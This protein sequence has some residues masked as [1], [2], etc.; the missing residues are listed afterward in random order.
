MKVRFLVTAAACLLLSSCADTAPTPSPN[1]GT[2]T[3]VQTVTTTNGTNADNTITEDT[4]YEK[5]IQSAGDFAKVITM[6]GKIS[7]DVIKQAF[8]RLYHEYPEYFWV[9]NYQYTMSDTDLT[10]TIDSFQDYSVSQVQQ[11]YQA[12]KQKAAGIVAG[13]P[14]NIPDYDKILQI[15]DYLVRTTQYDYDGLEQGNTQYRNFH[16]AYGCLIEGKAVCEGY[17]RAFQY[18]MKLMGVEA[19]TCSGIAG[20]ENHAWN[21]VKISDAYYWLDITWDDH[22]DSGEPEAEIISHAYFLLDDAVFLRSHVIGGENYF[23]PACT[24][25]AENYFRKNG[26]YFESYD[27]AAFDAA[28]SAQYLAHGSAECMFSSEPEYQKAVTALLD[29]EEIWNTGCFKGRSS[30]IT[31][32]KKDDVCVFSVQ[33]VK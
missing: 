31:Y 13:I 12:M 27:F 21:Y 9:R 10:L 32:T 8:E 17:A 2:Q 11:M 23:V 3:A 30:N 28:F 18:I 24:G 29:K 20:D 22:D 14:Q 1:T 5:L 26:L 6:K 15:H 7:E 25:T 33:N 4:F 16:T 19:G